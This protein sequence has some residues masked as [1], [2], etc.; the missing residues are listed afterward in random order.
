MS[1]TAGT[2]GAE[3]REAAHTVT[4]PR[5]TL[6]SVTTETAHESYAFA[7]MRCGHAWEQAYEIAHHVDAKGRPFVIYYADGVRVPSPISH[8]GCPNCGAHVVRIMRSGRVSQ[9]ADAL[10][11]AS[12]SV[13][14]ATE[15]SPAGPVGYGAGY[16]EPRPARHP[17]GVQHHWH[18]HFPHLSDL[19]RP[20]HHRK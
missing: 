11:L 16:R 10:H 13:I 15:Q 2:S 14:P 20:F 3:P 7:C 17:D 12:R 1:E 9:V 19:L 6:P 18:W 5:A 4:G 8:P